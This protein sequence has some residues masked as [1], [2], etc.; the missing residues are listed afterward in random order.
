M[1]SIEPI[2]DVS[3]EPVAGIALAVLAL[4]HAG[5]VDARRQAWS[6]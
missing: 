3:W 4:A 1:P 2:I 5:S 6:A